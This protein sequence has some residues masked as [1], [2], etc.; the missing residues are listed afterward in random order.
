MLLG[1]RLLVTF[2]CIER[3]CGSLDKVGHLPV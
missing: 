2:Q 3:N 1:T